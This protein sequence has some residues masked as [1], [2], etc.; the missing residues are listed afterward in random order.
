MKKVGDSFEIT[1]LVNM[2][3]FNHAV[4]SL[5]SGIGSAIDFLSDILAWRDF[6]IDFAWVYRN[7]MIPIRVNS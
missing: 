7:G 3:D 2:G 1:G 4:E 5:Q 6:L